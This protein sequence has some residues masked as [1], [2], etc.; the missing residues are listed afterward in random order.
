MVTLQADGASSL[1]QQ[2]AAL[3]RERI[4]RGTLAP[5]QRLPS[6]AELGTEYRV[7]RIT[8]RKAVG[9]MAEENLVVR[10][11]GRGT[12]VAERLLRHDV[13]G[14]AGIIDSI[15]VDGTAPR[16]RLVFAGPAGGA[17]RHRRAA[18][19]DGPGAASAAAVSDRRGVL[20][21]GRRLDAGGCRPHA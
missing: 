13:S 14:L 21:P 5:G 1:W 11:Q 6:E 8:V 17:S 7:S 16:T 9:T 20:R 15:T 2:M 12:F 10:S 4:A 19:H 18:A 3:L